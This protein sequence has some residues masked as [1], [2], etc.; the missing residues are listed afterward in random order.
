M[1]AGSITHQSLEKEILVLIG[2]HI[3]ELRTERWIR[4]R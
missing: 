1:S 3:L 4:L 2:D